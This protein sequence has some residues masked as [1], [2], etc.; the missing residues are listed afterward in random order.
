M[1][2]TKAARSVESHHRAGCDMASSRENIAPRH[3]CKSLEERVQSDWYRHRIAGL[4][5]VEL[6]IPV[7]IR[8]GKVVDRIKASC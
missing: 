3:A 8:I 7:A 6:G 1:P 5:V 4:A 2:D